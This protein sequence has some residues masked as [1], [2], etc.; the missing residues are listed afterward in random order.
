MEGEWEGIGFK[1][2]EIQAVSKHI[3]MLAE[4]L[5]ELDYLAS[6]DKKWSLYLLKI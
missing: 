6:K 5:L 1:W 2:N 3:R 4:Y